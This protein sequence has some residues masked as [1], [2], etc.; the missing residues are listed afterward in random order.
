MFRGRKA[1]IAFMKE[2]SYSNA[3]IEKLTKSKKRKPQSSVKDEQE[4][5]VSTEE[6]DTS[7]EQSKVSSDETKIT[8]KRG[9]KVDPSSWLVD[10]EV[11]PSGWKYRMVK[12]GPNRKDVARILT[13]T[14]EVIRGNIAA[15]A[16]MEKNNY[17]DEDKAKLKSFIRKSKTEV[18]TVQAEIST[19]E[20]M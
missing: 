11:Y 2:N 1:A 6:A 9:R 17:S 7:S 5:E 16:Y 14:G 8:K 20:Q 4:P 10:G 3:D 13:E 15:L 18:S 12:N 19:A